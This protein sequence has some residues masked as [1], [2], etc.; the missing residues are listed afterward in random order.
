MPTSGRSGPSARARSCVCNR[1][2]PPVS[3]TPQ[4]T[5]ASAPGLT[6]GCMTRF[7][8][9]VTAEKTRRTPMPRFL[10][11]GMDA[12]AIKAAD[13]KVRETVEHIL[14][15]VESGRDAAVRALS[16][17]FDNWAPQSFKLSDE[18][19]ERA[20]GKLPKRDLDDIKFA[21]AQ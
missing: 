14:N 1:R 20:M 5:Q 18:E 9:P 11:R 19:I 8:L 15:E 10:K 2:A 7:K 12:S 21:Q 6:R 17:K 3:K 4:R 13:A 16:Q